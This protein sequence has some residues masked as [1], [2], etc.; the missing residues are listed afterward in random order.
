VYIKGT[1]LAETT[2]T[3]RDSEIVGG[4]LPTALDGVSVKI[5][6]EDAYVYYVSPTQINVQVPSDSVVGEVPVEVTNAGG[7]SSFFSVEKEDVA[8]ALFVWFPGTAT[9]GNRY[10]GAVTSEG[11]QVIYI[12]K[13]G[14]LS[15]VGLATRSARPGETVL[16]FATGCGPTTPPFPAGQVVTPPIP[17]LSMPV[18][19]RLGGLPAEV[20]G[21]TGYLIFAGEC[22]FNVTVPT[23]APDGDLVVELW[24]GGF[25]AQSNI[26]ITVQR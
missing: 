7:K 17:T 5:N 8:P 10:V 11:Q 26:F 13:P 2:R 24:I 19:I 22:Q 21:G 18:E 1:G 16:L 12:G 25:K 6:T 23:G 15:P 3:W 4:R 20:A 14:L 9:E